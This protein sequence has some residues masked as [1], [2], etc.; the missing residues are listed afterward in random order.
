MRMY[1]KYI[2]T[3]VVII[4]VF[5]FLITCAGLG[6]PRWIHWEYENVDFEGS[7]YTAKEYGDI[8]DYPWQC[9]AGPA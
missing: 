5:V 7:L 3:V 6:F 9:V 2:L 1:Y 8:N 4:L